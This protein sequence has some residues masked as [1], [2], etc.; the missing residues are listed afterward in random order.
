MRRP[1]VRFANRTALG[2]RS[3]QGFL[4]Q[5]IPSHFQPGEGEV[6]VGGDADWQHQQIKRRGGFKKRIA[7][8]I[9]PCGRAVGF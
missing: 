9:N 6:F 7:C 5:N 2:H 8:S 1:L 3:R 4:E